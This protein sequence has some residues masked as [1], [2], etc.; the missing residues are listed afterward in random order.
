MLSVLLTIAPICEDQVIIKEKLTFFCVL[1][2]LN[3]LPSLHI[4]DFR[5]AASSCQ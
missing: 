4:I 5:G 2:S 1:Y 3:V